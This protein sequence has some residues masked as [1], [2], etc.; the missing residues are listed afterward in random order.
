VAAL[1]RRV[2]LTGANGQLGAAF[3]RAFAGDEV[4]AHTRASLDIA[5]ARAVERAIGEVRPQVIVNCA[6]FND[7][8]G[9]E[10]R[11]TDAFAAN[12]FAV[13][14]LARA[15]AA[16]GAT[17]VHYSTDFVFD[18]HSATPYTEESA[19]AP[20]SV[21]SASKLVGE[22]F[23]LEAPR[24][25]VLRVESLFGTPRG[26]QGRRGTLETIVDR[27]EGGQ[28]V[29]AFTDR[30]V[31]VTYIP[32]IVAATTHLLESGA[33]FGLYHCVNAEP[34]TWYEVAEDAARRLHV[35][36]RLVPV[37]TDQVSMIARRPRYCALSTGKLAATGFQ[38][39]AWR[40]ALERWLAARGA[41]APHV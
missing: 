16:V 1:K 29:R 24:V 26:W 2:L 32:D 3:V 19:P 36:P 5:D 15:A 35:T 41:T 22:W 38:M 8:D 25:F 40:Q 13:R 31:S 20:M 6:A 4:V 37:T 18:G 27:L 28:E 23:A 17:L 10:T 12:A 11:V 14:S 9:A 7:V 21:Y 30:V 39:P 34:A 33:P